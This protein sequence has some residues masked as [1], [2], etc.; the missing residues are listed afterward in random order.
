MGHKLY[1]SQQAAAA[2]LSSL[3]Y[4]SVLPRTVRQDFAKEFV[5]G[6]GQSVNVLAPVKTEASTYTKANRDARAGITVS[7]LEQSWVAVKMEDQV[8]SAVRL[9]DDWA[10]FTLQGLAKQVLKPQAE[11]VVDR[12]T[13]PLLT[14]M[15]KIKNVLAGEKAVNG[16]TPIADVKADGSNVLA[17]VIAARRTLNARRVPAADRFL[18]V[19]PDMEA[20]L[21]GVEQLQKVSEAGTASLLREATMGRLFGFTIVADP[22]LEA[23][24][25]VAYHRDAFAHVT[26]PSRVPE[27]AGKG[28]VVAQ[29]GFA[30][31]H[32]MQ[33][34][35]S[36]LEDQSVVDAFVGA[37]TLDETRAV[38]FKVAAGA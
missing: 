24:R 35:P 7:D 6:R 29:D 30:L 8:Y 38:A 16:N 21:L 1:T 27:G 19:G 31:R 15:G 37:T 23:G 25:A 22:S 13:A 12:M 11:A 3:R 28:A 34:N 36:H 9:P 33:Y 14:E 20:I 4:L 2:A 32:I 17:A 10:T 5:A 18:A 26:R